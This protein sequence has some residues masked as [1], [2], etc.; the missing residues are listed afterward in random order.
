M[1]GRK[2]P[3]PQPSCA[4][5]VGE[6]M[7]VNTQ[8]TSDIALKAQDANL[9]FILTNHPLDCPM[10]DKGGECPLQNQDLQHGP[11]ESRFK[12]AKRVFLKPIPISTEILLD[13]DRCILC[14]RCTRFSEEIAGDP[15]IDML[16]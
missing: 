4:V 8:L 5:A 1:G 10:C 7:V 9:E 15:F 14:Y 11:G 16:A 6:G 2:M 12:E 3:K 13:R